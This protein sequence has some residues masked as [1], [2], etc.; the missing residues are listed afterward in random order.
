MALKCAAI[1]VTLNLSWERSYSRNGTMWEQPDKMRVRFAEF[2]ADLAAGEL[3]RN[4]L[5]LAIQEK[6][7]HLLALLVRHPGEF[8]SR[9]E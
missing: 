9:E 8:V 1:V 5:R 6:P 3:Y 7:F 2:E 4:G